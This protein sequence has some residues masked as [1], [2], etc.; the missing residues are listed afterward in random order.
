MNI[1]YSLG[2]KYKTTQYL[3]YI[4]FN[5]NK[6]IKTRFVTSAERNFVDGENE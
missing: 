3:H 4:K 6:C 5:N 1:L 2:N